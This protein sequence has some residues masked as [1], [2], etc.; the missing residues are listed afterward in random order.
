[1]SAAYQ[2]QLGKAI[3]SQIGYSLIYNTL[4]QNKD[5]SRGN[6]AILSQDF[7]GLGGDVQLVKTTADA[8]SY[9][10]IT[11]ELTAMFRLQGGHVPSWGGKELRVLDH[12]FQGPDLVRGFAPSGLGPRDLAST[13]EDAVGG[14]MYWGGTAELIFPFPGTPKD[15]GLRGALFA[16]VGSVW[17][18]KG[19]TSFVNP[20]LLASDCN[21]DIAK[22]P[23]ASAR[24]SAPASSG[25]RRSGRCASTSPIRS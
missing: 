6:Y 25:R 14:T 18:Y 20:N 12:F 16:D 15:F 8:R 7:A 2:Q 5:P 13:N 3:T 17:G 24:R 19:A 1:L 4:D 22:T 23:A 21:T 10:P 9:Y 11:N